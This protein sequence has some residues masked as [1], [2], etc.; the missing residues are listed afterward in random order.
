MSHESTVVVPRSSAGVDVSKLELELFILPTG[1]YWTFSNNEAGVAELVKLLRALPNVVI[2]IEATGGYERLALYA[3][4]EAGLAVA[5]VNPRQVRDYAKSMGQYAKTDRIDAAI[6]AKFATTEAFRI[7]EKSSEKQRKLEAYI[8]RRRQLV[9]A[10]ADE[11]NRMTIFSDKRLGE[12]VKQVIA[13][14]DRQIAKLEKQIDKLLEANVEWKA[15]RDILASVPGVGNATAVTL[16]AE[17]PELGVLNRQ[18]I[19]SLAGVAPFPKD[20]GK[21]RGKRCVHGGRRPLR[22]SMYMAALSARRCNPTI[23]A[24][25]MRLKKNGKPH[26]VI[27]VACIRK[28]LTILNLMVKNDTPWQVKIA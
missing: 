20:S 5:L 14:Y 18:Q 26:K 16:L 28:L 17:L 2:M 27:Q 15:K 21:F 11:K 3:L 7:T 1:E 4:Q 13:F 12:S 22:T 25:A 8:L 23:K 9:E 6:L 24:F 10:R 19:A